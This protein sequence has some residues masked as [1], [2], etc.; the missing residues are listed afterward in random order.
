MRLRREAA[1]RSEAGAVTRL[2]LGIR[3]NHPEDRIAFLQVKAVRSVTF[4]YARLDV[5]EDWGRRG[6]RCHA[7]ILNVVS[8][9]ATLEGEFQAQAA[10]A[11][12]AR[13]SSRPALN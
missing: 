6:N 3:R 12:L 2:L 5:R 9:V 11:R 1:E 10:L 8:A 7:V 4:E 13:M